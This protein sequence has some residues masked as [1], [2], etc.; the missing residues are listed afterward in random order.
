MKSWLILKTVSFVLLFSTLF[1]ATLVWI[2]GEISN[3]KAL[4]K[5]AIR[6]LTKL[7][8]VKLYWEKMVGNY[9]F[10][11]LLHS[12]LESKLHDIFNDYRISILR[13]R[14]RP[15]VLLWSFDTHTGQ[16]EVIEL[17]REFGLNV[18]LNAGNKYDET[19][20]KAEKFQDRLADFT[21]V[22]GELPAAG[23]KLPGLDE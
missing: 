22:R 20:K 9:F 21:G 5:S 11:P 7:P 1:I 14:V 23:D 10:T 19:A 15:N 6:D 3:A 12:E 2:F 13:T 8:P 16:D 17:L 4:K 18:Q